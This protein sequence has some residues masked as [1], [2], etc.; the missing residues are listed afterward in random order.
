[1]LGPCLGGGAAALLAWDHVAHHRLGMTLLIA[2]ATGF[3]LRELAALA[4]GRGF[5]VSGGLAVPLAVLL[6]LSQA[7]NRFRVF[8]AAGLQPIDDLLG[9]LDA[10]AGPLLLWCAA[11]VALLAGLVLAPGR[12]T[13]ADL[14]MTALGVLYVW[15]PMALFFELMPRYRP[16]EAGTAVVWILVASNKVSDSAAY[17]AG[18]FFGRHPMAPRVSPKKTWEGAVV[19]LVAGSAAGVGAMA[20]AMPAGWVPGAG[21]V[22]FS[23]LCAA[24]GQLG[25][26]A[27]SAVKR[28]ADVKDSAFLLPQFGGV[29]DMIDGFLVSVPVAYLFLRCGGEAWLFAG[30]P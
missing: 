10:Q 4:R 2:A 25:D 23:S 18:T 8:G 7:A 19:G 29:L 30:V 26:L 9:I 1:V 5:H 16:D 20:L 24:A 27:E 28:W 3:A 21:A 6:I 17:L 12:R 15:G 22:V 11:G 14:G 13:P